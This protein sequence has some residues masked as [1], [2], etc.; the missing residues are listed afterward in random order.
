MTL[1]V[2]PDDRG[3]TAGE[4]RTLTDRIKLAVEGIWELVKVAYEGRAWVALGY[5]SWDDYCT[6]EFG[7]SRI[8]LPRE[9]RGE[10]VAS[11]RESGL[12][13][14]AIAAAT[15]ESE[16]TVR[17]SL[18][19][20]PNDAVGHDRP[21]TG[22]NGKT[23]SPRQAVNAATRE[24]R[25]Q[26]EREHREAL[27]SYGFDPD[28]K[29]TPEERREWEERDQTLGG[30]SIHAKAIATLIDPAEVVERWG[31]DITWPRT[32]PQVLAARDWLVAFTEEMGY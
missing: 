27:E 10:V 31:D 7:S 25:E 16:A 4:A 23:Y 1:A 9:E 26:D 24:A 2:L 5:E 21:V 6:R 28:Y 8:R 13:T 32:M 20:A 14:R 29:A 3:F 12:S 18:A 19:T 17:R 30:L 22:V 15:G 11:L